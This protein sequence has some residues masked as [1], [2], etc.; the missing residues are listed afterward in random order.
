[1][2]GFGSRG[3]VFL[4]APVRR[5]VPSNSPPVWVSESGVSHS[6]LD[7]CSNPG[8]RSRCEDYSEALGASNTN[9]EQDPEPHSEP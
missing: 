1:M 4:M 9:S 2:G 5:H 7:P 3:G 6:S 8:R